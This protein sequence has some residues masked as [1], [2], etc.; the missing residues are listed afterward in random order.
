[1]SKIKMRCTTCGKWFQSANAKEVTCPDCVQKA[2]KEKLA[3]KNAPA[4][5]EK[6]VGTTIPTRVA[7][8]PPPK[9]KPETSGTSHWFDSVSDVKIGEPD[10]PPQRPRI[11]G[12][13]APHEPRESR[14]PYEQRS[15]GS[16]RDRDERDSGGYRPAG[17]GGYRDRDERGPVGYRPGGYRDRDERGPGSYRPAGPGGYRDRDERGPSS[18]RPGGSGSPSTLDAP[19]YRPRQ[20]MEGGPGRGPRPMGPRPDGKRGGKPPRA[21]TPTPPKPKREKIPP[22]TPFVATP[23]QI[24]QIET[25]YAELA[26]PQEFDGIRTQI[27]KELGIPKKAVKKAVQEFRTRNNKPSWWEMQSYKG[28]SEELAKIKAAYEPYLPVPV[29]GI[30]KKI[31]DELGLKAGDVYQAVKAIRLEMNLPQF[32]DPE[33]HAEE[34]AARQKQK[35][36]EKQAATEVGQEAGAEATPQAEQIRSVDTTSEGEK[37]TETHEVAAKNEETP[38]AAQD[39]G[40]SEPSDS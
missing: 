19:G 6:S 16:Y 40:A 8:P 22:P 2:R 10:K 4:A 23:E 39:E 1:M 30:H 17:P 28:D 13:P 14:E 11:P 38:Q 12:S 29:V 3:A 27:A 36:A 34:L 18:Y 37:P 33:L 21:K 35:E 31:A 20:P 7:P 5:T 26:V 9:P 15:P 24:A 25:R 32:N